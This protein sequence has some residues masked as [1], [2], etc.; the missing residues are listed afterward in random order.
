MG[1]S[2]WL[3]QLGR[4]G[5]LLSEV[6]RKETIPSHQADQ[7][8]LWKRVPWGEHSLQSL[9]ITQDKPLHCISLL[10]AVFIGFDTNLAVKN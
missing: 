10:S 2:D 4:K 3:I 7:R 6:K 8:N 9:P 1:K 5:E